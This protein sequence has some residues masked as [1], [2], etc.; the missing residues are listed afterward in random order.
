MFDF[1]KPTLIE[2][3]KSTDKPI[4]LYGMGNGADSI[5]RELNRFDMEISGVFVSDGF[6][7]NKTFHG[8]RLCSYSDMKARYDNM[9]VLVA[10]GS[11]IPD[12]IDNIKRIAVEQELY[13][14]YVPVFGD[15]SFD[16]EYAKLHDGDFDF[17]YS[18][19]D[20]EQSKHTYESILRYR[21]SG[22]TDA[23]FNCES[24]VEGLYSLLSL[25]NDGVYVD[26]GA[27][28][29][30]TV[31][32]YIRRTESYRYIYAVEPSLKTFKKLSHN[33]SGLQR[34]A[35]YNAAAYSHSNGVS[36]TERRGRSSAVSSCGSV[37]SSVSVDDILN[38][39]RA[40]YIKMDIEG[41]ERE[42]IEGAKNTII[43]HKPKLRIA[44]YHKIG[45]LFTIPK[46]VLALRPDYRVYLRHLKYVPD[47]D[48]DFIFL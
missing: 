11:C 47:W 31:L 48:T 34:I 21:Y 38:G 35:L 14:P 17:I 45:D 32:D 37:M 20:D 10:F 28:T 6:V 16:R 41:A 7:R 29:G 5:I 4:V 39:S 2:K 30:D 19:L 3:L 23:L 43:K 27:N 26:L 12:V 18:I 40:D 33:T 1:T 44:A 15:G 25:D 22:E 24:D 42:A 36:F 46:Q 13:A 9:L 8:H